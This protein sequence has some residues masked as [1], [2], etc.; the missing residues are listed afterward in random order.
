MNAVFRFPLALALGVAL[1]LA[2]C[3]QPH[4]HDDGHDHGKESKS[5]P[6]HDH[7]AEAKGGDDHEK[8]RDHD[9]DHEEE[10]GTAARFEAD[11][12]LELAPETA[13]AIGLTSARVQ[14]R[15]MAARSEI[16]A[17]VFDAGPP[18][19]ASAFVPVAIAETFASD[20][21]ILAAHRDTL[22]ALGQIELVVTVSGNPPVGSTHALE[23]RAPPR[24]VLCV[25]DAAVLRTATGVFVYVQRGEHWSRTAVT[26]AA[27]ADGFTA[28]ADGLGA[29]DTVATSAVEHLWLTE[30][31][32]TKGGGHSH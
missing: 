23:L 6:A 2:G 22:N 13:A 4:S 30:L 9:H 5:E 26:P 32:L 14:T 8:E 31:R 15:A 3:G 17:T 28:I 18:A 1:A 24:E 11:H 10:A 7:A 16:T 19:R 21:R 29:S 25:P 12:G 20:P 27:N